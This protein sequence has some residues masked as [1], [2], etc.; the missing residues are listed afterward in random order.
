MRSFYFMEIKA[1]QNIFLR[2]SLLCILIIT[3]T[4][5]F[6]EFSPYPAEY[7]GR[8]LMWQ[9]EAVDHFTI[10]KSFL[11]RSGNTNNGQ[12]DGCVDS[13]VGSTYTLSANMLPD[14]A[15]VEQAFLVWTASVDSSKLGDPTDNS[16]TLAFS[17]KYDSSRALSQ[18]VTSIYEGY[19]GGAVAQPF[20]FESL[21][22]KTRNGKD[23]GVYT[24]RVDVTG[25]L[26]NVQAYSSGMKDYYP[27]KRLIGDYTVS[28][29]DCNASDE[30]AADNGLIAGWAL[31]IIYRSENLAPK[32]L[33]IFKGLDSL[34]DHTL[35]ADISGFELGAQ[36]TA[37]LTF[38]TAGGETNTASGSGES[39]EH[40]SLGQAA[41][42][43]QCNP[44]D[45]TFNSTSSEYSW[46]GDTPACAGEYGIDADTFVFYSDSED[47]SNILAAGNT[48]VQLEFSSGIDQTFMNLI[49]FSIDTKP[50]AFDMPKKSGHSKGRELES[51]TCAPK[52]DTYCAGRPFNYI[53][54][55][56]NWGDDYS[57]GI[58]VQSFLPSE[59]DYIPGSTVWAIV[60]GD[61]TVVNSQK[62]ADTADGAFPFSEPFKVAELLKPCSGIN[63][64]CDESVF[65]SFQVVSKADVV[66]G[67][68]E[69]SLLIT[70]SE[71]LKYYANSGVPLKLYPEDECPD[72]EACEAVPD[73]C[74]ALEKNECDAGYPCKNSFD[75]CYNKTC[76]NYNYDFCKD[77]VI[78]ISK[79]YNDP[80]TIERAKIVSS[81]AKDIVLAAFN[82]SGNCGYDVGYYLL[83]SLTLDII[84]QGLAQRTGIYN[85]RLYF[86]ANHNG[87]VDIDDV[88]IENTPQLLTAG[89]SLNVGFALPAMSD[90]KFI[91]IADAE[92]LDKSIPLGSGFSAQLSGQNME[93]SAAGTVQKSD[94]ILKFDEY[95]FKP[96]EGC[97]IF[98][99]SETTLGYAGDNTV[100][101]FR[102]NAQSPDGANSISSI[103]ITLKNGYYKKVRD[104]FSAIYLYEADNDESGE[105]LIASWFTDNGSIDSFILDGLEDMLVFEKGESRKFSIKAY[106][107]SDFYGSAQVEILKQGVVLTDASI[108]VFGLPLISETYEK[109]ENYYCNENDIRSCSIVEISASVNDWE[110]LLLRA[111]LFMLLPMLL[112]AYILRKV[113]QL[114]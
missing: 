8:M 14:D 110:T 73:G 30:L 69:S 112:R 74:V 90:L 106:F 4:S 76:V 87:V 45:D 111:G 34:N 100:E 88:L 11:T 63:Q 64:S 109:S 47:F 58:F 19:I 53:F 26:K 55:I 40:I 39:I 12:A 56:E 57:D 93:F 61:G 52:A 68:L 80:T 9:H 77:V 99:G 25:F 13:A 108:D 97:F 44:Q 33:Y 15:A 37:R 16:V 89:G 43:N 104:V 23:M 65:I 72:F 49:L 10:L 32:N 28:G 78:N 48:S 27:G 59:V 2:L 71:G 107:N 46:D 38:M 29:L 101:L 36:T 83:K 42:F 105:K 41:L 17:D 18:E 113:N 75:V 92:Y 24:Y 67:V 54:N 22:V 82:V 7:N 21:S 20:E 103:E 84:R 5:L 86:D 6:G 3:F 81:P 51:C 94:S 70:D 102:I 85:V 96:T 114:G 31:I 95:L 35:K 66:P 1:M 98:D 50:T 60:R 91:I 62:I 79:P